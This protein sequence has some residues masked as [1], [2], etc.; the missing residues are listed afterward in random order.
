VRRKESWPG[1]RR[2]TGLQGALVAYPVLHEKRRVK[3]WGENV[4]VVLGERVPFHI[5]PFISRNDD[6]WEPG[7]KAV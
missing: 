1:L 5:F 3:G 4:A 7:K 6:T 2:T